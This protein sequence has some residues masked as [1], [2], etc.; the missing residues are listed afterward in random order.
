MSI[1][2]VS[3]SPDSLAP[4]A[5]RLSLSPQLDNLENIKPI[6]KLHVP[7]T[8]LHQLLKVFHIN[9]SLSQHTFAEPFT[10]RYPDSSPPNISVYVVIMY[11][12]IMSDT[13]I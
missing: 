4:M 13:Q 5:D 9:R 3:E 11:C 1:Q 12:C 2:L 7:V 6:E 8:R 10:C